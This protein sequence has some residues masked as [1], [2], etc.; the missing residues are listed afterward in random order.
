M[1]TLH[2]KEMANKCNCEFHVRFFDRGPMI[3]QKEGLWLANFQ[4]FTV[5]GKVVVGTLL[6]HAT[7]TSHLHSQ[8]NLLTH[9]TIEERKREKCW[10]HYFGMKEREKKEKKIDERCFSKLGGRQ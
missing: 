2:V 7:I 5:A 8:T 6:T 4:M 9:A 10:E 1:L 3:T